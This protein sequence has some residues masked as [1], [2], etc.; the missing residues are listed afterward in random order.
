VPE[1][2]SWFLRQCWHLFFHRIAPR[3][4]ACDNR[5]S[6]ARS[7]LSFN[8]LWIYTMNRC[9]LPL[10]GLALLCFELITPQVSA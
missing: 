2:A 3:H 1:V 9:T 5:L 4:A 7:A 6:Q 10:N 8:S